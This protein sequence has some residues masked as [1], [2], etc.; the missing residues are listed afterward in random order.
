MHLCFSQ[1]SLCV[2]IVCCD[3]MCVCQDRLIRW[4]FCSGL[5]WGGVVVRVPRV[6]VVL[7]RGGQYYW[8][9]GKDTV[10]D[11]RGGGIVLGGVLS[12]L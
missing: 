3:G 2:G 12:A 7:L 10:V 8:Y 4:C 11:F 9:L 5:F 6:R 1:G